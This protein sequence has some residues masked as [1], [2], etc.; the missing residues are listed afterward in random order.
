MNVH[1]AHA[2]MPPH[3]QLAFRRHL[4]R[5]LRQSRLVHHCDE[6]YDSMFMERG[7]QRHE[8]VVDSI[9]AWILS[10]G[11]SASALLIE[12]SAPQYGDPFGAPAAEVTE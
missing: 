12:S 11:L 3:D 2:L 4:A 1:L 5:Y 7:V 9:A 6:S 8:K 10:Q